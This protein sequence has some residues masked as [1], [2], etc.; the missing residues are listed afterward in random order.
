MQREVLLHKLIEAEIKEIA[1]I[2][3]FDPEAVIEGLLEMHASRGLLDRKFRV[4]GQLPQHTDCL[5]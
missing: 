3:A 5:K 1:K 2:N 4:N